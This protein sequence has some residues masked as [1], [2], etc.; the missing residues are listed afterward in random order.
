[1]PSEAVITTGRRSV[2]LLQRSDGSFA[3]ADVSIGV[4]RGNQTVITRGLQ[5]GQTIV[6]SGQFLIDSEASLQATLDRLSEATQSDPTQSET[7]PSE[8]PR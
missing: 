1:V 2:V 7:T 4:Q 6:V 3:A 8:T 5:E